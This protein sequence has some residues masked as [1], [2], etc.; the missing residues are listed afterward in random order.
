VLELFL[1]K[2]ICTALPDGQFQKITIGI[3]RLT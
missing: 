1:C 2:P 3:T